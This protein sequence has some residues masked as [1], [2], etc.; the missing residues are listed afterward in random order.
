LGLGPEEA[1][2][3]AASTLPTIADDWLAA[4]LS[5]GAMYRAHRARLTLQRVRPW[6]DAGVDIETI[7]EWAPF[8]FEP[9][10]VEGWTRVGFRAAAAAAWWRAGHEPAAAAASQAAGK[11]P[12]PVDV[13]EAIVLGRIPRPDDPP[14]GHDPPSH[15]RDR[16]AELAE[17][18]P[19]VRPGYEL[20]EE[21]R[22]LLDPP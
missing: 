1:G 19:H 2:W 3:Y 10:D 18:L 22:V 17:M 16:A 8:G 5:G 21:W 4:G 15:V 14:D 13:R 9:S 11:L 7:L 12:M 20:P 6:L